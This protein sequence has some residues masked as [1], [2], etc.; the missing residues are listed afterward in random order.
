MKDNITQAKSRLLYLNFSSYTLPEFQIIPLDLASQSKYEFM[1]TTPNNK[2]A[3]QIDISAVLSD[4]H[5]QVHLLV[6]GLSH[7]F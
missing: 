3:H 4:S 7:Q 1:A 2:L 5:S 6:L